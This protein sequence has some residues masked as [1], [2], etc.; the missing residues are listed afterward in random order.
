MEPKAA[1][2]KKQNTSKPSSNVSTPV[3]QFSAKSSIKAS[4]LPGVSDSTKKKLSMF[5]ASASAAGDGQSTVQYSHMT[6]YFLKPDKIK[7]KDKKSKEDPDYNPRTLHVPP[8][9]L[10]QQTPAQRQ[11]W[12]LKS[13]YYD[14]VLFFKMGK[15]YELFHMD[16]DVGVKELNLVY[17]KG[18]TAHAGFPEVAY[19]R[20]AATLVEKGYK[21]A[22]IEQTETPVM[23]EKRVKAMSKPSKFD[24]VVEREVCQVMS[25]GTRINSFLDSDNFEGE[26]S[27]LLAIIEKPGP[28]FGVAF[29]DTTIGCFHLS[30]FGDDKNLS[31][32]RTLAAHHPPTEILYPR[33]NLTSSTLNFLNNSLQGTRKEALKMGS[34]FWDASKTLKMLAEG[35]YFRDNGELKM[36]P[37]LS[38][39]LDATDTLGLTAKQD[40][41]E[42]T[43]S[44]LGAI[45]WY[46]SKGFLDQQLLSQKKF[47]EYKPVD[48]G[49]R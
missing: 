15:F 16:A 8:D 24:K 14:V 35:E 43:L 29:I 45:V 49:I 28:M 3:S 26:P 39:Y 5:G 46:L 21:V 6:H 17:M 12:T 31:R 37:E 32:L 25:K 41:G 2:S 9:F 19:G 40:S 11:W 20:Y 18:E 48:T 30:Q 38:Q 22:R 13:Q 34:E 44:A 23:M 7:D 10:N 4:P 47:E 27:Y 42:L 33:G 36:P 1:N